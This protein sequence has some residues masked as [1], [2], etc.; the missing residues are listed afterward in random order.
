MKKKPR[1]S[2]HEIDFLL[3]DDIE[4][5][6]SVKENIFFHAKQKKQI[7]KI[8]G[9]MFHLRRALAASIITK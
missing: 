9:S 5:L 3:K 2:K 1:L 8:I 6:E 4:I 7:D